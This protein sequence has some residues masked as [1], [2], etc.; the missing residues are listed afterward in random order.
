M[1]RAAENPAMTRYTHLVGTL[2]GDTTEDAMRTALER[3][4]PHLRSLP[5]GETGDR[6]VW[7]VGLI[8]SF[9]GHPDL[10]VAREGD[11]SD[12]Q[13][14]LNYRVRR[15]HQLRGDA[16]DLGYL[17]SYRGSRPVFD[18][19][20]GAA[21]ARPAFQ[22]GIPGDLDL[23]MFTLGPTR[24]LGH[25]RP[26]TEATVRELTAIHRESG[27]D[28]VFQVEVPAETVFVA[29]AGPL[30]G[31][32]AGRLAAGITRLAAAAPEG[33]RFGIHLCLGD[34][35]HRA[36]G[37]L[38]STRPLVVLANAIARGWPAGRTLEY[39]HA[40]LAAGELPPP[41]DPAFHAPLGAL[42]LPA[43]TRFVA[44]FLHEARGV[45]EQRAL[46]ATIEAAVGHQ[47]DVAA[48][49]GLGRRTTEQALA[50]LDQARALC[51]AH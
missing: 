25:R 11:W 9:R 5:D 20:A 3:V 45:D 34:L 17:A 28:V 27:G 31:L 24:L 40:P 37:V 33:A 32:A 51:E 26:F 18:R 1:T 12:Y 29:K 21:G 16:L 47:V 19:L 13:H 50:T 2:P 14:Q 43:G 15:G 7:I 35:G 39:V 49:C 44:G 41:T 48:A 38:H 36:L 22:V 4:G 10:E 42:R 46:L 30:G 6:R 8:E 23:A